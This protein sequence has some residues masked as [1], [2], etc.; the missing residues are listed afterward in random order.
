MKTIIKS[1]FHLTVPNHCVSWALEDKRIS[2]ILARECSK[3]NTSQY[4]TQKRIFLAMK[5]E[6]ILGIPRW[7]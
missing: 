3:L 2:D 5:E 7:R 6:E 4:N 1:H